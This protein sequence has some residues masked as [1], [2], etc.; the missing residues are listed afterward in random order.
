[1][2]VDTATER[3]AREDVTMGG[4]TIRRGEMVFPVIGSANRDE[5]QFPNPDALDITREPNRHLSFGIGTHFCLG[6][7]LAR[8]EAQ[9]AL[10]TLVR[11]MP[12]LGPAVS[13]KMLRWRGGLVLR[14]LESLPVVFQRSGERGASATGATR[15][16]ALRSLTLPARKFYSPT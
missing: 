10:G 3:F 7:P 12:G 9:I 1:C 6:A 15:A 5:R 11:R 8:L 2:P 16:D 13:Q 4:V 14:G